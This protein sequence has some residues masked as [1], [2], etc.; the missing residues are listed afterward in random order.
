MDKYGITDADS[1]DKVFDKLIK[2]DPELLDKLLA[3][4]QDVY[5]DL[6]TIGDRTPKNFLENIFKVTKY[7]LHSKYNAEEIRKALEER[8]VRKK[9]GAAAPVAT[10]TKGIGKPGGA[11]KTGTDTGE[12]DQL[13]EPTGIPAKKPKRKSQDRRVRQKIS[14]NKKRQIQQRM[15]AHTIRR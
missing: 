9:G 5:K 15:Q 13:G 14:P 1:F 10:K 8:G 2:E 3:D 6:Y 7:K 11:V 12:D 4:A